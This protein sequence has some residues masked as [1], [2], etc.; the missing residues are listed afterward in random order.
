MVKGNQ[1]EMIRESIVF[2]IRSAKI[3]E[4]LITTL[5]GMI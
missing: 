4:R 5:K 3:R 1:D 2:E